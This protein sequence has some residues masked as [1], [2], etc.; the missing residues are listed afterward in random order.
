MAIM[1]VPAKRKNHAVETIMSAIYRVSKETGRTSVAACHETHDEPA[2][3]LKE[4]IGAGDL[5][6]AVAIRY[7]ALL[8]AC[9]AK[10]A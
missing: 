2:N 6:E 5:V 10:I 8:R 3:D 1:Y 7:S 9:G 4:V